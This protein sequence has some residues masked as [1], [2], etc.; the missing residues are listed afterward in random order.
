MGEI[1]YLEPDEEITSVID[2]LRQSTGHRIS[3]V[4]PRGATILQSVIN[5]KLLLKEASNLGKEIA[6]VTADKIGR[7]LAAQVGLTVYE[8]LKDPRPIYQPPKPDLAKEEVLEIDMRKTLGSEE[9]AGVSVHHFQGRG[10]ASVEPPKI[11]PKPIE[12]EKE[13]FVP[14]P[15][16]SKAKNLKIGHRINWPR[17]GKIVLPIL[18]FVILLVLVGSYF[19]LPK[20]IVNIKVQA[21]KFQKSQDITISSETANSDPSVFTGTLIDVSKDKQDQ[22]TATGQED[23]GG[24]ASG[25]IVIYNGLDSNSHSFAAGTIL[26]SSSKTFVL[27]NAIVVPG[28][29]VQNLKIVPGTVNANIE[30][31]NPGSDSN[32]AAG[33]FAFVNLPAAEQDA[34]YGQSTQSLSGGYSKQVQVISQD[35]YNKAQAQLISEL[36]EAINSEIQKDAAGLQ[37]IDKAQIIEPQGVTTSANVGDQA[38]NFTMHL[39]ERGRVMAYSKD[40]FQNFVIKE[41]EQQIPADKM[42]S[43]GP[44]DSIT[45]VVKQTNYDQKQLILTVSVTGEVSSKLD[46]AQIKKELLG[47]NKTQA[48]Q[49][50][51][52]L[53]G[54]SGSEISY[55]PSWWIKRIPNYSRNVSV[56]LQ[57]VLSGNSP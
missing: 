30:A 38:T 22:F 35:D 8:S 6:I 12:S 45:P 7:N 40:N 50:L 37:I 13:K 53:S 26:S 28:A 1:L 57:Y 32:V 31:Q 43:L 46:V 16:F 41:M 24:K 54:V 42:I 19:I 39:T 56:N 3:L 17:I 55:N 51:G 29:T 44:D 34:I 49:L 25:T 4:V 9:P 15:A 2:K 10:K 11:I 21:E 48:N 5:L 36:N 20:V 23:L 18:G 52:G 14:S 27:K 33:R 47:K